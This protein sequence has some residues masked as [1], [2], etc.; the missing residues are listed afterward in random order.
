MSKNCIF[1]NYNIGGFFN[2]VSQLADFSPHSVDDG[3]A[4][5]NESI[6]ST[7]KNH[8]SGSIQTI[9]VVQFSAMKCLF[10]SVVYK[11]S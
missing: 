9:L 3:R 4:Q 6:R 10:R 7:H 5:L 2:E 8:Q 1:V 11:L